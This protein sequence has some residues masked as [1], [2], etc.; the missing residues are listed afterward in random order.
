MDDRELVCA[1]MDLI[2]LQY[3]PR[4]NGF[5]WPDDKCLNIHAFLNKILYISLFRGKNGLIYVHGG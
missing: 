1:E 5:T 3:F 2:E 4:R